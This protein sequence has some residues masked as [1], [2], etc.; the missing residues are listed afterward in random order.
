MATDNP[1]KSALRSGSELAL[2]ANSRRLSIS[3]TADI[4]SG[5]SLHMRTDS[6][7]ELTMNQVVTVHQHL[8]RIL[9]IQTGGS[10]E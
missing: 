4:P 9:I 5:L 10:G 3:P 7:D 6:L 8:P 1:R 2:P